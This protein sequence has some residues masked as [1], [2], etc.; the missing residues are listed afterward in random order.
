MPIG[1]WLDKNDYLYLPSIMQLGMVPYGYGDLT[2]TPTVCVTSLH[3]PSV[4]S[5][6]TSLMAWRVMMV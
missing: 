2:E 1:T 5:L 4:P 3:M 6:L